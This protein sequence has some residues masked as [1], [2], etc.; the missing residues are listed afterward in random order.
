M[1]V[2]V[3]HYKDENPMCNLKEHVHIYDIYN[4]LLVKASLSL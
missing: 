4:L 3:S 1:G 2:C